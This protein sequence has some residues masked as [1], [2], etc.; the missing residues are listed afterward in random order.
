VV[1]H[2]FFMRELG[3]ASIQAGFCQTAMLA[4]VWV[5]RPALGVKQAI[6][7]TVVWVHG[8]IGLYFWLRLQP[9]YLRMASL[10][11]GFAFP[12]PVLALLGFTQAGRAEIL[13]VEGTFNISQSEAAFNT[14]S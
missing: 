14:G 6:M 8:C 2:A 11:F 4:L 1:H 13:E 3:E 10:L 12:V 5:L 7:L 9:W